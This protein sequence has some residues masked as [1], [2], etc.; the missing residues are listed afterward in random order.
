MQCDHSTSKKTTEHLFRNF[1]Q[2]VFSSLVI[3]FGTRHIELIEDALQESFYKALKSWNNKY[4]K[5]PKNWLYIVAKNH[6]VNELKRSSKSIANINESALKLTEDDYPK[7]QKD[8][9]LQLLLACS[10]L[11][12]SDRH[13][14]IFTLKSICGFGVTEIA[15][16]LL[17][18]EDNIYKSHQRCKIKLK[19]LPKHYFKN[20]AISDISKS[21]VTYIVTIL[22]FMFNEGYDSV[23]IKSKN[24]INEDICF[25]ALRL[26]YL[27]KERSEDQVVD[28]FLALCYFHM[29]RFESR[30]DGKGNFV[31]LR[32]QDRTKWDASLI[33]MG[34]QFLKKPTY[35]NRFYIEA[36]IASLHLR[37][38]SFEETDWAEIIKLYDTLLKMSNS[39]VIRLNRAVCL[40]ELGRNLEASQELEKVKDS[41]EDNYLYYSISMAEYLK[42]KDEELS[43]FWYQKSMKRT[44]QDFRKKII[45]DKLAKLN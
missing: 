43:K 1:Y 2:E 40:F 36:L 44:N 32:K 6:L 10:R 23:S 8:S 5:Q 19:Q 14:L 24:A 41:L 4:P 7:E 17:M 28:H 20:M 38:A 26:G 25:E 21:E 9:Q 39:D 18:S 37:A 12:V 35:L 11:K 42:D 16:G 33:S 3:R 34:F 29:A 31:S 15:N 30:M 27:L 22:Y 13:K 45:A